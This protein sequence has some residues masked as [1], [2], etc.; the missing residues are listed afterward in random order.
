MNGRKGQHR[1][2]AVAATSPLA[3]QAGLDLVHAGG[4]AVDAAIAAMGVAMVTEPGVVSPMG[5]AFLNVWPVG[6]D[7]VVVDGSVEMPGRGLARER[8]GGGLRE[9]TTSY[10]GGITIQAG[11]GSVATPGVFACFQEA[12]DRYGSAPWAELLAPAVAA[13]ERGFPL[14]TA[15]A[16]YLA[17]THDTLFGWDDET[18]AF[19]SRPD[20]AVVEAGDVLRSPE[21]ASSLRTIADHGADAVYTG[22]L[23]RVLVEDMEQR[24]GLVTA[25]DLT[26]YRAVVR[27]ALTTRLGAWRLATN[28]PPSIGGPVLTALLRLL[29][30]EPAP[31]VARVAAVQRAVLGYRRDRLDVA[32]DLEAAGREL[33]EVVARG[34]L[35]GL[36]TSS[37]TAHVSVV[38]EDGTACAVTASAGYGSGATVPGTGLMLNNCL[39]EPELNRRG[40]HALAPGTRLASNMAPTTAVG[41]AGDRLAI[42]T[43][44]ADRITTALMQVLHAYCVE[45]ADL[46]QAIDA[47]RLHISFPGGQP[48]V[49]FEQDARLAAGL[50][51]SGLPVVAH[52]STSMYFG[53]VGAALRSGQS[54]L[55]AAADPRRAAATAVG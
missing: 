10:G 6:G 23:G 45:G 42:G 16:S 15:A 4:N 26:A 36:P 48:R 29:G 19:L 43:P 2:A 51:G 11:H 7:P 13:A 33:L 32:P 3:A 39:G 53:G 46:Q 49:E 40:L 12:H 30:D 41:A 24:G 55:S 47:P 21:L 35:A 31:E 54:V 8:F 27:P 37:S 34:G 20:G 1:R 22:E 28:P 25:A 18:H 9:I 38:D 50:A 44:G 5:G 17:I 52:P 14:G